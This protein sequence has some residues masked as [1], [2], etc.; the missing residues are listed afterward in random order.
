MNYAKPCTLVLTV[1]YTG[2]DVFLF[3]GREHKCTLFAWINA[4]L[5]WNGTRY[6]LIP[7]ERSS[8]SLIFTVPRKIDFSADMVAAISIVT[9][10]FAVTGLYLN[11]T[12]L[13]DL[14]WQ[15]IEDSLN[16]FSSFEI[17]AG[18]H[19]LY[20]VETE[21][22]YTFCHYV[23]INITIFPFERCEIVDLTPF[24]NHFVSTLTLFLLSSKHA[25]AFI[26]NLC[27]DLGLQHICMSWIPKQPVDQRLAFL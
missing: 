17:G 27:W 10:T 2:V 23:V 6:V 4:C 15:P 19:Q 22:R 1:I 24:S 20:T 11:D 25:H 5:E 3:L 13:D 21:E 12:S 8:H 7:E 18:F 26:Q 9:N 16:W 14:D